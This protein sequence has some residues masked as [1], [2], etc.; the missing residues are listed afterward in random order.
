MQ[1]L[2]DKEARAPIASPRLA[3]RC[4]APTVWFDLAK[5][6]ITKSAISLG[7]LNLTLKSSLF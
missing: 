7:L 4:L 6:V 5:V 3:P 2:N 1:F